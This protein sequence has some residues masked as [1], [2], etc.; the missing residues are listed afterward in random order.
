MSFVLLLEY[1]RWIDRLSLS[2][3]MV[4]L[5]PFFWFLHIGHRIVVYRV[6][7]EVFDPPAGGFY[8]YY[9]N[10]FQVIYSSLSPALV[11]SGGRG[12]GISMCFMEK[13]I[14]IS[15]VYLT[16]TVLEC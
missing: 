10:Y 2:Y 12:E 14:G 13:Q 1:R 8:Q 6:E 7:D 5:I 4:I 3:K 16:A 11:M 15:P 9:E